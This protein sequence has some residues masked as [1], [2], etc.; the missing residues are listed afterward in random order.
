M[1]FNVAA[2][3]AGGLGAFAMGAHAQVNPSRPDKPDIGEGITSSNIIGGDEIVPGSRPYLLSI[4]IGNDEN[5]GYYGQF[6]GASLIAPRAIMTAAHCVY[7]L[8]RWDPPTWVEFNRHDM[9]DDTGVKRLYF[10]DISQCDGDVAVHPEFNVELI[11]G[12][13]ILNNDVAVL[14]LPEPVTDITPVSLNTDPK[15]PEEGD[16]LDVAGWGL[17]ESGYPSVPSAVTLNYVSNDACTKK[18]Y[19]WKP[20]HLNDSHL[21]AIIEDKDSCY[22]DSG[23]PIVLGKGMPE[24]GPKGD[25]AVAVGIVSFGATRRC[26]NNRFPGIYTRVSEVADW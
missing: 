9:F 2:K 10:D 17:T 21:C 14:F 19:R 3:V 6:C 11:D 18:P 12:V 8:D 25:P 23:S 7:Y 1:L 22:G 13:E 5:S 20:E 24:E 15:I 16:P 4:G 26:A